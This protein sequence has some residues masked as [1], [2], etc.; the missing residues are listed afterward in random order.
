MNAGR[1][2]SSPLERIG[3]CVPDA[4]LAPSQRFRRGLHLGLLVDSCGKKTWVHKSFCP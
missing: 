3:T 2:G 1:P 4:E